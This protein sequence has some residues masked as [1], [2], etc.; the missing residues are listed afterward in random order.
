MEHEEARSQQQAKTSAPSDRQLA[1]TSSL[2]SL[3]SVWVSSR[4]PTMEEGVKFSGGVVAA[5][6]AMRYAG[7]LRSA[8]ALGL[9]SGLFAHS[10]YADVL[11]KK[12]RRRE[13]RTVEEAEEEEAAEDIIG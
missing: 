4:A 12:R 6:L 8:C 10:L 3:T 2:S 9:L 5:L 13:R 7:S 11:Q 1:L